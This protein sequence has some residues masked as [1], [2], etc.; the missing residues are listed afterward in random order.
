MLLTY[1]QS[2]KAQLKICKENLILW[3]F[4]V[5]SP[6]F[7]KQPENWKKVSFLWQFNIAG[8]NKTYSSLNVKCLIFLSFF[9]QILIFSMDFHYVNSA[10]GSRT[11]KG[12]GKGKAIPL[13]AWRGP[14]GSRRLRFPDFMTIDTRKW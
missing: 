8:N 1:I 4:R 2:H 5:N 9:N 7:P 10:S 13:E 3:R 11:V 14:E 12:K 6:R